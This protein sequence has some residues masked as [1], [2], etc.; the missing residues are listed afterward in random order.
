MIERM[1]KSEP[2]NSGQC[3]YDNGFAVPAHMTKRKGQM[4]LHYQCISGHSLAIR[5]EI[6][7]LVFVS[8]FS[9]EN[10]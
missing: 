2:Q 5:R 7:K 3:P 6:S 9:F 10:L 8:Y 1:Q 4:F